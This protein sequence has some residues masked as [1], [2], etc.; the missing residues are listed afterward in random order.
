[1]LSP[2]S[3]FYLLLLLTSLIIATVVGFSINDW[4]GLVF[5]GC[6]LVFL[7]ISTAFDFVTRKD[8]K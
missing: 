7:L 4:S 3:K 5:S 1:M 6:V 8:N 2:T